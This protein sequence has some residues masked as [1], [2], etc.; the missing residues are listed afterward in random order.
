MVIT[1][2]HSYIGVTVYYFTKQFE[3]QSHFL[4]TKGFPESHTAENI[5][6]VILCDRKLP[7]HSVAGVTT[8]NGSI[9]VCAITLTGWMRLSCFSHTL[10]LSVKKAMAL[11]EVSKALARWCKLVSHFNNFSKSSFLLKKAARSKPQGKPPC[12][13]Y[14]TR[15]NSVF[16]VV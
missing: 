11:P 10:Q 5:A 15:W 1:I 16:Y 3:L 14:T 9:I 12:T 6:K 4:A 8:Y 7:I 2:K 13:G